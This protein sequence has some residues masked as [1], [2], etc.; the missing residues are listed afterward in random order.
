[1]RPASKPCF[2]LGGFVG[3]VVV[4]DDVDIERRDSS[5][6]LFEKIRELG[7]PVTL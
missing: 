7:R 2:D 4:H 5:I 3:G 1:M 6:D